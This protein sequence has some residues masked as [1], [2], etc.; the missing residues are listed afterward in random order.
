MH[1]FAAACFFAFSL[2]SRCQ[3]MFA[4][5]TDSPRSAACFPRIIWMMQPT[6]QK[7]II[8]RHPFTRHWSCARLMVSI[9][10]FD[11]K[12]REY[13]NYIQNN[14]HFRQRNFNFIF[15]KKKNNSMQIQWRKKYTH[16]TL[17]GISFILLYLPDQTSSLF[18]KL[19]GL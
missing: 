16:A 6:I 8:H 2:Y 11:I 4:C 12:S 14:F 3:S 18:S 15:E 10:Y 13:S 7:P 1:Y 19:L 17:S 9:L 5:C